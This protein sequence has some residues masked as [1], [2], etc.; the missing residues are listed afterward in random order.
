MYFKFFQ[1][2]KNISDKKRVFTIIFLGLLL[3]NIP[4]LIKYI[5]VS[6]S[7]RSYNLSVYAFTYFNSGFIAR[8]LVPTILDFLKLNHEAG[9]F[10]IY[11]I[12]LALYIHA[13]IYISNLHKTKENIYFI[14]SF[15]FLFFGIPH[16]I[17]DAFRTDMIIQL[18]AL[19]SYI[20]IYKEKIVSAIL[21]SIIG[22]LIHEAYFFIIVPVFMLLISNWKKYIYVAVL[23]IATWSILH[24]SNKLN[25]EHAI[26]IIQKF[27]NIKMV[28]ELYYVYITNSV[29]LNRAYF[30]KNFILFDHPI[31][32]ILYVF[33]FLILTYIFATKLKKYV[34]RFSFMYIFPLFLCFVAVDWARWLCFTYFLLLLYLMYFNKFEKKDFVI[35]LITTLFI[36]IPISALIQYSA[37]KILFNSIF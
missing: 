36:G 4:L 10:F 34:F 25:T 1:S 12:V 31:E 19:W 32:L 2:Y 24:F 26:A 35:L 11:N 13:V 27:M 8:G 20:L 6:H 15:I 21:I 22:L 5:L 30:F 28:P 9:Y 14:V 37:L 3:Y 7:I 23:A 17:L 29:G 16:F 33:F 18:L